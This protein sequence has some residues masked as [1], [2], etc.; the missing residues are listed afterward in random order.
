[1]SLHR[2][3]RIL[4]HPLA[5]I[6]SV[7]YTIYRKGRFV[8]NLFHKIGI[9]SCKFCHIPQISFTGQ[10]SVHLIFAQNKLYMDILH[11]MCWILNLIL[12]KVEATYENV[13]YSSIKGP[14]YLLK[15]LTWTFSINFLSIINILMVHCL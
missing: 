4:F 10:H 11:Y 8:R 13:T 15:S 14:S 3:I 9:L 2:P 12:F 5:T 1:M 7:N 6:W